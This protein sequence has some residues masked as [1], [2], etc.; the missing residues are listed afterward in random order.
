MGRAA[1]DGATQLSESRVTSR[2]LVGHVGR[3]VEIERSIVGDSVIRGAEN[4]V[5]GDPPCS[6]E[7]GDP[8]AWRSAVRAA[9]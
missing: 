3:M 2:F 1:P 8:V 9:A 6:A 5:D 4:Q 7:R